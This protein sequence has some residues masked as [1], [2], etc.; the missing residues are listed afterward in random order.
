MKS[1]FGTLKRVIKT[2]QINKKIHMK[3]RHGSKTIM[4]ESYKTPYTDAFK[5]ELV[6]QE[7]IYY[8]YY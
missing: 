4:H 6:V 1:E 7:A 2:I 5:C 3:F 8:F